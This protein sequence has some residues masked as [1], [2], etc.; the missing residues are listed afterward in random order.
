MDNSKSQ[1]THTKTCLQMTGAVLGVKDFSYLCVNNL[2]VSDMLLYLQKMRSANPESSW[3][4]IVL[5]FILFVNRE[6]FTEW[7]KEVGL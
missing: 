3:C 5:H 4:Q 2:I 1:M 6:D 7:I